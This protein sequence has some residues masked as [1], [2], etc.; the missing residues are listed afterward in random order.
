VKESF[1]LVYLLGGGGGG[2]GGGALWR[3]CAVAWVR[4]GVDGL[5][6]QTGRKQSASQP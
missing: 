1:H 5:W 6:P 3:G 2:G 4:W